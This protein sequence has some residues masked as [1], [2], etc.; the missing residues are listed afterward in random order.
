[1][2]V[3]FTADPEPKMVWLKDGKPIDS[4][5]KHIKLSVNKKELEHGLVEYTCTL[6]I[7]ESMLAPKLLQENSESLFR[8]SIFSHP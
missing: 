3:V 2:P 6:D 8:F 5:D 1:M 7:D 4:N